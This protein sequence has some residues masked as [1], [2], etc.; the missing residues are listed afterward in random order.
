LSLVLSALD[1]IERRAEREGVD[2]IEIV[3]GEIGD[4]VFPVQEIDMVII[5]YVLHMLD[6]PIEFMK[7]VRKYMRTDTPLV[8]I[9]RNIHTERAHPPSFMTNRNHRGL[10]M[11]AGI[12][13]LFGD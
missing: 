3:M 4:L 7:N 6:K 8:T 1:E 12:S 11:S 13:V 10:E 5:V 2:N 9:E